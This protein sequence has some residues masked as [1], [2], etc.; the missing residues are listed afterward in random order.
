[1][2]ESDNLQRQVQQSYD[3][4]AKEFSQTRSHSWPEI[5]I[6]KQEI[7]PGSRVLDLGCGNGRLWQALAELRLDYLGID[8]SENL[9]QE[10][11]KLHPSAK[12]E[13]LDFTHELAKL[14]TKFDYLVSIAALHHIPEKK[15]RIKVFRE[16][17][18]VLAPGGELL[19]SVWN[20]RQAKYL[21][22][23][24]LARLK[25]WGRYG[26]NDCFIPWKASRKPIWRY[27]H[28]FSKRELRKLLKQSGFTI[29]RL[30]YGPG[31]RNLI[32]VAS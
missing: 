4:I 27:Y 5:D 25:N 10:A 16:L 32:V 30:E 24:Y 9:I 29:K 14:A 19:F 21:K 31:K 8:F 3:K 2:P 1:M 22:Y 15:L 20:L 26:W 17:K 23:L 7:R 28:A 11:K 13:I 18:Q 12:F 6:L